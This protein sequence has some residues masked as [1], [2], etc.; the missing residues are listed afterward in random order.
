MNTEDFLDVTSC[1]V[2]APASTSWHSYPSIY[3]LGHRAVAD[4]LRYEV[5][6]EE[7]V[8]G[9]VGVNTPILTADLRYIRA[10]ELQEGDC[11]MGFDDTLNNPRLRKSYVTHAQAFKAKTRSVNFSGY[12]SIVAT[13]NHPWLVRQH[14]NN[15]GKVW[16]TTEEL[17]PGMRIVAVPTWDSETR[18]EE[19]GYLAAAYDGEGS[20]VRHK[21]MRVLSF[22]QRLG[23]MDDHVL[24]LLSQKN[25]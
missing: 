22:Y 15:N 19:K 25:R 24:L 2:D 14:T 9:C 8:D 13:L 6:V 12:R 7:K 23:N 18:T 1:N 21:N 11:L 10:G 17:K 20:L 3:A 5:N 4:L 16:V